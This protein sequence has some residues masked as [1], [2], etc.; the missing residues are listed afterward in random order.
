[1]KTMRDKDVQATIRQYLLDC[2]DFSDHDMEKEPETDTEKVLAVYE[3]FKQE[4]GYALKNRSERSLFVDWLQGLASTLT[5][6]FTYYDQMKL[7]VAWLDIDEDR[8]LEMVQD[9]KFWYHC[10]DTYF[11]MLRDAQKEMTE[12]EYEEAKMEIYHTLQHP[13]LHDPD[14]LTYW[15]N[16]I[17]E[18]WR[19]L[20][21]YRALERKCKYV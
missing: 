12:K 4:K 6:D 18:L 8:A 5:V 14:D 13:D 7:F 20:E 11:R 16:R 21:K 15:E 10:M 1:M 17:N 3:T 19:K 2:M 9:N